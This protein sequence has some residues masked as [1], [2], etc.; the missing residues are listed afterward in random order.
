MS[1]QIVLDTETTG[2]SWKNGHRIIEIGCLE[3]R[4]RK[5]TQASFHHYIQPEREIDAGAQK[6]HG[7]SSTFLEGKPLIA[8]LLDDFIAFIKDSEL[9]IHN[10][11]FDVGF[12]NYE[13]QRAKKKY[14]RLEDYCTITDSLKLAREKHPGR[15]NTLDALCQRYDVDL[16]ERTLHGALLDARLLAEVYLKMTSGQQQLFEQHPL[17]AP[18]ESSTNKLPADETQQFI[19]DTLTPADMSSPEMTVLRATAEEELLHREFLQ[20]IATESKHGKCLWEQVPAKSDN[21]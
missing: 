18:I 1:K 8:E 4:D 10:A 2:L 14:K 7:I 6:V 15:R 5:L 11:D 13:L 16:S 12:I 19:A 3:L 20:K 9:I 21:E 17:N